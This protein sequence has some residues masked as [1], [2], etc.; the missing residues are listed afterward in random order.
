MG[1]PKNITSQIV[2]ARSECS[3]EFSFLKI[4]CNGKVG[5][6]ALIFIDSIA[7]VKVG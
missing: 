5:S 6:T 3:I 7:N 2:L 1:L 4:F